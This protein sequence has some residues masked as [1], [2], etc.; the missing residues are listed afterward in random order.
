MPSPLASR[1]ARHSFRPSPDVCKSNPSVNLLFVAPRVPVP[2]DA[3]GAL[4]ALELLR[5]LDAAFEVTVLA[6]DFP[7]GDPEA[8]RSRLRARVITAREAT[9]P[10]RRWAGEA[11][12]L[13][14]GRPLTYARYA[15]PRL[16]VAL[17][18]HLVERPVDAVHF[19]HLHTAQFL[20]EVRRWAPRTRVVIDAHNVEA[21]VVGRLAEVSRPPM[22]WVLRWQAAAIRRLEADR[23]SRADAV[24][25]CST[26]DA[27][28]LRGL[29]A[30]AVQ[31]IPNGV[32]LHGAL[33]PQDL[34][35]DVTF[36][37]SM[38]WRPNGDA[39]LVL[40][41]EIWPRVRESSPGLRLTLVG[42]NPPAPVRAL[43]ASDVVVSGTVDDV[44]PWLASACATAIPLRAGSGTRLKI[45]E[46]A[47]ARVPIVCTRLASE[48]LPFLHGRHLL[49]AETPEEFSRALCQLRREP[50]LGARLS[51]AAWRLAQEFD[52][53]RIGERLVQLYRGWSSG[54]EEPTPRMASSA[55][56]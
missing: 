55:G 39:A 38:D 36:V 52:W 42:R 25:A 6:V 29:G 40:A 17:H 14:A 43:A 53:Q 33:P 54:R 34:R 23:V 32:D 19:D 44:R 45:L 16:R 48:G 9:S 31:V 2:T 41:R 37:G 7:G 47:A 26:L 27:A 11:R 12:S 13:L 22:R 24:L 10:P 35:R 49:H 15:G 56:V 1:P 28:T 8:L 4:R 50:E 5:A 51:E 3:G 21:Q 18:H 46:A 20:P 30:R